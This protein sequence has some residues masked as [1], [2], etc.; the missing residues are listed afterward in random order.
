MNGNGANRDPSTPDMHVTGPWPLIELQALELH[1]D[2]TRTVIRPFW[3]AG[4]DEAGKAR[5]KATVERIMAF[6]DDELVRQ[7]DRTWRSLEERHSG[8]RAALLRRAEELDEIVGGILSLPESRRLLLGA[9]FSA[10]YAFEAAAL[11]NPSIVRHPDHPEDE[12]GETRFILSLRGIGEGHL[13][14]VTF[15]TGTWHKDGSVTVDEPGPTGVPPVLGEVRGW[16]DAQTIQ[17]DCTH[18]CDP[19]E[20]VLFPVLASQS[21]GIEDLR[22]TR[23]TFPDRTTYVGTYTAVGQERA[24]QELIQTD[25]FRSFKMHPVAGDLANS[26][27]MALFP[28]KFGERYLAIGRQDNENLWLAS[29]EDLFTWDG[30]TKLATPAYPWESIQLGNCGSPLEIEEGW[31]LLTHGVGVMRNYCMGAMLL[32]RDDPS[33]LIGRLAEPLIEPGDSERDGYVPN[34][35]YSCGALV[36]GRSLLLPYAVADDY[37]RF[38]TV[39]LDRLVAELT[40]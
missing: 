34:V 24:C 11:F 13:S 39:S 40:R 33:K 7:L 14:S 2:P 17:I 35:V 3:P 10:E 29:S 20:A 32:D 26:K 27:G 4:S 1:P 25:D 16:K 28:R 6:D 8:T 21:R 31:L 23:F 22:L 12:D 5:I 15:R 36:R 18:A 19:S 37:T 38:A 9:Y 30:G